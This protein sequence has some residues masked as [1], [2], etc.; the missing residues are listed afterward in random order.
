MHFTLERGGLWC[1]VFVGNERFD[2]VLVFP[3]ER[4]GL[5]C[6]FL[7]GNERFVA[8]GFPSR[9]GIEGCVTVRCA[10]RV[11]V[12][13]ENGGIRAGAAGNNVYIGNKI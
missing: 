8:L 1:C 6:L 7:V 12:L 11:E 9:E 3:L 13:Q 2:G 4:G 5:W 10:A